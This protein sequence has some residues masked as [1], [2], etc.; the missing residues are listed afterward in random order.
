VILLLQEGHSI[1]EPASTLHVASVLML[2]EFRGDRLCCERRTWNAVL[3]RGPRSQIRDLTTLRTEGTP[4]IGF[5]TR[6]LP[7]Q[8]TS[9]G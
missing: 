6:G 9:H 4:G 3:F 7:A 8:G 5:P 2:V 1:D